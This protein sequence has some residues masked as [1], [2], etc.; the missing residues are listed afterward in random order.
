MLTDYED[1]D[2]INVEDLLFTSPFI[3]GAGNTLQTNSDWQ[4]FSPIS[5]SI[6]D[7][8][9]YQIRSISPKLLREKKYTYSKESKRRWWRT[10][11]QTQVNRRNICGQRRRRSISKKQLT[12]MPTQ[13]VN[14][15]NSDRKIIGHA[16]DIRSYFAG[17]FRPLPTRLPEPR[18]RNTPLQ[19]SPIG[20]IANR[21]KNSVFF[22]SLFEG[23]V[24]GVQPIE[25]EDIQADTTENE[26]IGNTPN[27][28]G[29]RFVCIDHP[30]CNFGEIISA[31]VANICKLDAN[32]RR[33]IHDIFAYKS[34]RDYARIVSALVQGNLIKNGNSVVFAVNHK[35]DN[36]NHV[37]IIHKCAWS[38]SSCRCNFLIN[39]IDLLVSNRRGRNKR[40]I[41]EETTEYWANLLFYLCQDATVYEWILAH[42]DNIPGQRLCSEIIRHSRLQHVRRAEPIQMVETCNMENDFDDLRK[43]SNFNEG[44]QKNY[45]KRCII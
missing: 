12:Y 37:H 5:V 6:D 17:T 19:F 11:Q 1:I 20:T 42:L 7:F 36:F 9:N 25:W 30:E 15:I 43:E 3:S 26:P 39:I 4:S 18:R 10:K 38:N 16:R 29:S 32:K 13:T 14:I 8:D 33:I 40:P 28:L 24:E 44:M 41:G 31:G 35:K 2:S 27:S 23:L 45:I 34:D 22:G 21:T